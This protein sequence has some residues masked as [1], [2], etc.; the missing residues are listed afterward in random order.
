MKMKNM[1]LRMIVLCVVLIGCQK[2]CEHSYTSQETKAATCAEEGILTF[3]CTQCADTY[4]QPIPKF[5]HI[6]DDGTITKEPTCG[7]VGVKEYACSICNGKKTEEIDTLEHTFGE[8]VISK[9]PNCTEKGERS[10]TCTICGHTELYDTIETNDNHN[11]V[12]TVISESTCTQQGTGVDK[13]TL[14]D[15]SQPC[16]YDL[17]AHTYGEKTTITQPSCT[18]N[19]TNQYTCSVCGKVKEEAIAATGHSWGEGSCNSP[20]TCTV[21]GYVNK[22]GI[23]HDYVLDCTIPPSENYAGRKIYMCKNCGKTYDVIYDN[24]TTFDQQSLLNYGYSYAKSLGFQVR[25]TQPSGS[26]TYKQGYYYGMLQSN[27]GIPYLKTAMKNAV[28]KAYEKYV[29]TP[30]GVSPYYVYLYID[31]GASGALGTGSFQIRVY[32]SAV[33]FG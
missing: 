15:Y 23:G 20:V 12:N 6:W 19:G 22:N 29:D 4:T 32:V 11:L 31:Y 8:P 14:C 3:T 10:T 13:C 24:H 26:P 21:C 25:Y 27:G 16:S 5:E 7:E 17:K 33:E 2:T 18:E 9:E 1:L 28:N 30:T